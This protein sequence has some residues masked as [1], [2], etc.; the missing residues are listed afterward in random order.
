ME[1]IEFAI[2]FSISPELLFMDRHHIEGI[3]TGY[4]L[5]AMARALSERDDQTN[6]TVTVTAE[7]GTASADQFRRRE[8]RVTEI[9]IDG[10]G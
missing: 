3:V 4:A 7:V 8:L 9:D 2:K 10:G 1:R 6:A 5:K